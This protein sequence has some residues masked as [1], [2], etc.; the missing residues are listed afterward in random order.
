MG[1][2]TKRLIACALFAGL[3]CIGW[4][5]APPQPSK[6]SEPKSDSCDAHLSEKPPK[7]RVARLFRNDSIG[8]TSLYISVSPADISQDKLMALGCSLGKA[9]AKDRGFTAWIFDSYRTARHYDPIG[10]SKYAWTRS[11]LR[12][13]YGFDRDKNNQ[14]FGWQ[15]DP[16]DRSSWIEFDLGPLPPAP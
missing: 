3:A 9:Y 7:F 11:A 2:P 15:P 6:A 13:S 4:P 16:K 1:A 12:A 10:E 5:Q 8:G 14:G